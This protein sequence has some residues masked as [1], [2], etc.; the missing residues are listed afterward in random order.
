MILH[1]SDWKKYPT[2]RIHY[3]TKNTSFIKLSA[4]LKYMGVKNHAFML[5]IHDPRIKDLN[6]YDP[7]LTQKEKL[8]ITKE[9]KVNFWYFIREVARVPPPAG[10][11]H[12]RLKANRGNISLFWLFFNHITT[13]LI[14]IRQTGKSLNVNELFAYLINVAAVN[15][16]MSILTKDDKLRNKT[17]VQIRDI[18]ELLPPYLR[19]MKA[20]DIKNSERV[21]VKELNNML[22]I[23]V[24]RSDKKAADN[25]GRGMTTPIVQVDEFGYVSNIE[26]T[27]PEMLTATTAA[28][29]VAAEFNLPYGTIFSTTPGKLNNPDGKF[30]YKIYNSALRWNEKML[31]SGSEEAIRKILKKNAS[32]ND[33]FEVMLLE[34]NHR[35]LGYTDE[36]LAERIAVA[37]S[38]GEDV[39]SNFFNKWVGGGDNSPIDKDM[40]EVI[41]NSLVNEPRVE[42]SEHGY[43]LNWYISQARKKEMEREGFFIAG[44]DTSD[45]I[46][47]DGIGLVI[48]YSVTGEVVAAGNYNET[49]LI[50]FSD[51]LIDLIEANETLLLL[52]ERKSSGSTIIDYLLK[53]LVAK[54]INP[55]RKIFNWVYNDAP[56]FKNKYPEAFSKNYV[57]MDTV[58]KLK[59]YF[60]F[61]TSGSGRT[62]RSGLYGNVFNSSIKYTSNLTRNHTLVRQLRG[63]I[64]KNGRIDHMDGEHDDMVIGWLLS[65][66]FLIYGENKQE[67][68][69]RYDN[70][71]KDVIN[72]ELMIN[73]TDEEL[74]VIKEQD[75]IKDQ[76]SFYIELIKKESN[77]IIGI[78][79]L[80]KI[81]LLESK[82]SHKLVKNFN[83]D[84]MLKDIKIMKKIEKFKNR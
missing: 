38:A 32:S 68:G 27:L 83:I 35:Q 60:G 59:K 11:A 18:I 25:V 21:T 64:I 42:I 76:I 28:R 80:N 41:I 75:K 82:L 22:N 62:S 61:S 81:K 5:A 65:Y 67:Y 19:M 40:L 17:S 49:N 34:Y 50:V 9:C 2:A 51:Y 47:S 53:V 43:V 52:I 48:R 7:N 8:L 23:Y 1:L 56:S 74:E 55:F 73:A 44:I 6:P 77:A 45:A 66:W 37:T 78:K 20:N 36:W 24:G 16:D 29:E 13:Y 3:E 15:T 79:I 4:L 57:S 46:G 71:L 84:A 12:I 69:F 58:I 30:A 63:L 70:I 14:Q 33:G 72:N 39:D 26:I 54:N 31:D 10:N